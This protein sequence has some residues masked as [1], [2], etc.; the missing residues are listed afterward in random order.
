VL[1]FLRESPGQPWCAECV[2]VKLD[3]ARARVANVFLA[4]EGVRGFL[5]RDE[6]C[7]GCG[8][9]RLGLATRAGAAPRVAGQ[10]ADHP[11]TN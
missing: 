9:R 5:R 6:A 2:A 1:A 3:L 7:A 11:A 4:A 8:R 10:A